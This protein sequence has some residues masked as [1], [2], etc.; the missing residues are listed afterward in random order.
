MLIRFALWL[1]LMSLPFFLLAFA[2]KFAAFLLLSAF[3]LLFFAF[4]IE[5]AKRSFESSKVY[6]SAPQRETRRF[7]FTQN[8][9]NH[10]ERLF[11]FKRLQLN[12][13]KERQ[14]KNILEENNRTHIKAL[15]KAI[16]RELENV[17]SS[18]SMTVFIELQL[19][20]RRYRTQKNEQALLELH[21]KI[22]SLAGK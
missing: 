14:R 5:V 18:I 7:L 8:Q 15:S 19:E 3:G 16:D 21:K 6:F 2:F 9:K 12:Y 17:K 11:Y 4:I 22:S 1:F 10:A 13:F 20:N